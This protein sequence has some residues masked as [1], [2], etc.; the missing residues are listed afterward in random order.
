VQRFNGERSKVTSSSVTWGQVANRSG[1]QFI[2]YIYPSQIKSPLPPSGFK[3][4]A[5]SRNQINLSWNA[6]TG[7]TGYMI[8][9]K[10]VY[11][12]WIQIASFSSYSTSY[13]DKYNLNPNVTYYYRIRAIN[14]WGDYSQYS[15]IVSATTKR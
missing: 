6:P 1:M 7:A 11:S 12:C 3:A 15:A 4:T 14:T 8:D 9:R 10:T 13:S 5:L 2:G